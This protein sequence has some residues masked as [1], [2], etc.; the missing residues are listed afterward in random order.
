MQFESIAMVPGVTSRACFPLCT[1]TKRAGR[2]LSIG[3]QGCQQFAKGFKME[4][5]QHAAVALA[6]CRPDTVALVP[7]FMCLGCHL[8]HITKCQYTK[9]CSTST[10]SSRRSTIA[11][12][13]VAE[14]V[15]DDQLQVKEL[16]KICAHCLVVF[17][18]HVCCLGYVSGHVD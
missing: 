14:E 9:E 12:A 3:G 10:S 15:R 7:L 18:A 2:G 8:Q 11:Q 6:N 13:A 4:M 17:L 1:G 5:D 16:L